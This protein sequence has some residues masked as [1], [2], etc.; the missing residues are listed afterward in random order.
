MS[1]ARDL[2][3]ESD[4]FHLRQIAENSGGTFLI[5]SVRGNPPDHFILIYRCRTIERLVEDKPVYRDQTRLEIRIPSRYPAPHAP[6]QL[7]ILTPIWNP[8][9]YK[10]NAVC[11]GA[12]KTTEFLDVLALRVGR[13][14]QFER[15]TFDLRDPANNEAMEWARKNL[16][17]FPTDSCTFHNDPLVRPKTQYPDG[18]VP[19]MP[20][21]DY[22]QPQ[23][24]DDIQTHIVWK[25]L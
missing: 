10:N 11:L 14:L 6:P 21:P 9:I 20:L 8:H 25:E 24:P 7:H 18:F 12:W 4:Y 22:P 3:L 5:E 2:R 1:R 23:S 16:I 13:L 15:E 19:L 17:L